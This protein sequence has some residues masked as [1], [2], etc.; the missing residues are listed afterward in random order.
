MQLVITKEQATSFHNGQTIHCT[1]RKPCSF[2]VSPRGKFKATL[3]RVRVSGM[4]Q[5][6]KTR[7]AEFRLPVKYGMYESL[8]I[9][10]SNAE[11]FHLAEDCPAHILDW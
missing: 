7:P 5:T 2:D 1:L 11:Q 9:N 4:C 6:W 3:D 10:E 8:A